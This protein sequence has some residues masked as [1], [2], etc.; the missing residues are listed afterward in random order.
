MDLKGAERVVFM[1]S[2]LGSFELFCPLVF[3]IQKG[4]INFLLQI[5]SI[6][7]KFTYLCMIR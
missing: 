1:I 7:R 3:S 5:D 6:L 4:E 2:P